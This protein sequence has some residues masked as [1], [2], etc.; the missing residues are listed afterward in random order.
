MRDPA[1]R[2]RPVLT[3]TKAAWVS[4]VCMVT[5]GE[6]ETLPTEKAGKSRRFRA[7][8]FGGCVSFGGEIACILGRAGWICKGFVKEND[9]FVLQK[10]TGFMTN[11]KPLQ[12]LEGQGVGA[13]MGR[14]IIKAFYQKS[15]P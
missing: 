10:V 15:D 8:W 5:A 14:C 7:I 4:F 1:C 3:D 6:T 12:R 13:V 2:V 11:E 9:C